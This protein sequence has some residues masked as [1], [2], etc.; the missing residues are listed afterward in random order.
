MIKKLFFTVAMLFLLLATGY[1][2]FFYFDKNSEAT[3]IH[4]NLATVRLSQSD[5]DK[6]M[7]GDFI[8]RRGF[9]FFSDYI[10][11]TL[12][13]GNMDVTHAGIIVNRKG[14]LCVIHSL[15]SDVAATDGVQLQTL[16]DFLACSMPGKVIVTR[17]L[18]SQP[19]H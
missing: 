3:A 19:F 6:I 12:N 4:E 16:D 18:N 2:L 10:S 11:K 9:G 17:A 13:K 14:R 8:L 15:S 1:R 5:I 7:P